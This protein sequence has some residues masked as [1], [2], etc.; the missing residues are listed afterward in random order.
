MRAPQKSEHYHRETHT[1]SG[2]QEVRAQQAKVGTEWEML[3][4]QKTCVDR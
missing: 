3:E 1:Y 4:P 2:K